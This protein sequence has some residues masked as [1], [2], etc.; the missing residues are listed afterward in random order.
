ME[1]QF[2][3]TTQL[4]TKTTWLVKTLLHGKSVYLIH[5]SKVIGLITPLAKAKIKK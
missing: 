5:R 1:A 2:I 3:T 4:R